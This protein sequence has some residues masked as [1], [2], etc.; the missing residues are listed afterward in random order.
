MR[1]FVTLEGIA[2]SA[3]GD[4]FNMYAATVPYARRKLLTPQTAA[5]RALLRAAFFSADGRRALRQGVRLPRLRLPPLL[6]W[7]RLRWLKNLLA[8]G[9]WGDADGS[10]VAA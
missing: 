6:R 10:T 4:E 9:A 1:A 7:M 3:D 2:L 8:R 5:G